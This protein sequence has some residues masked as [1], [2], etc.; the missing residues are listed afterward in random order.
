LILRKN[1]L[2]LF[3]LILIGLSLAWPIH[4]FFSQ[5]EKPTDEQQLAEL[6]KLAGDLLA[7]TKKG[8][9]D[10]ARGK[11][12]QLA[13]MFP[14]QTLPTRIRL[15]SLNAVTQSILD[16]K[17]MYTSS[18]VNEEKLL[19]HATQVRVAIDALSHAHQPMWKEYYSPFANQMQNLL[20]ASVERDSIE[21]RAQFEE[22]YRL[23]LAIRPA[24]SVQLQESQM[25]RIGAVYQRLQKEM[26]NEPIEWQVIR[27]TL[28][29]LSGLMQVAFLGEDKSA[30]AGL[31]QP[32]SPFMLIASI[33]AMVSLVLSYV[34][35]KKYWADKTAA[36]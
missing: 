20:Q 19:W 9:V 4:Y 1:R 6:D 30:Q 33:T 17:K 13:E 26:R 29:E 25:D 18:H 7:L 5:M 36:A 28:R 3:G 15:E 24:M 35:W 2:I 21:F 8:E 10:A 27:E 14:N 31:M 23:Y 16:A 32:R 11:L 12:D 34:A 22:N